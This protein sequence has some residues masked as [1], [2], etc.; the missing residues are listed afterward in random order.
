[1]RRMRAPL[2][3]LIVIFAVSVLGLTLIPGQ[4]A[5]GRPYRMAFFDA[6]YFMSYTASTIGF[7]EL[8]YPFTDDQRMWVTISI[9]L[10]VDRLG[11]RDR[12]PA[13][14]AAGPRF[15]QALALQRFTR[16]VRA[17]ARA[18]PAVRRL[19]ADRAS[20][21]AARFDALGQ[22]FV[23]IDP[24]RTDRRAGPGR[25]PRRRTR[26]GRR[27]PQPAPPRRRRPGPPA[28]RGVLALTNDDEANLPS[29]WPPRCC[30]PSCR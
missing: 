27:R 25:V 2:I 7:G 29:P 23:V 18:V 22:Q 3:I 24:A 10:T 17:A 11:V 9:Y 5:E 1:M 14:P 26:A 6:F 8:P 30:A 28:L 20:C 13:D 21:S 4:D 15:R 12:L 16:K 19:R